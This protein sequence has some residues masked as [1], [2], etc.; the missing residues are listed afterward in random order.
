[1]LGEQSYK[2]DM[3]AID[4]AAYFHR[5]PRGMQIA[6]AIIQ[7]ARKTLGD[8]CAEDVVLGMARARNVKKWTAKVISNCEVKNHRA[9]LR[10]SKSVPY[11]Y[12]P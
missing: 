7:I 5:P 2:P 3:A 6:A 8:R 1:M 11:K 12:S 10:T 9:V 4:K